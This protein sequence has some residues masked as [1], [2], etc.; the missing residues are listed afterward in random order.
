[1]DASF[2][3]HTAAN[4]GYEPPTLTDLGT[5]ADMTRLTETGL[6]VGGGASSSAGSL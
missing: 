3:L 1:M 6:T 4:S 5:L 2:A